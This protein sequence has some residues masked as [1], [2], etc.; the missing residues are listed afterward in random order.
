MT[1]LR[2]SY[3]EAIACVLCF[4][5]LFQ[6][7]IF[8]ARDSWSIR[9]LFVLPVFRVE[10]LG[11]FTCNSETSAFRVSL[12]QLLYSTVGR[13]EEFIVETFRVKPSSDF[14]RLDFRRTAAG[15]VEP[16]SVSAFH[17]R[18]LNY[19]DEFNKRGIGEVQ[20]LFRSNAWYKRRYLAKETET[21]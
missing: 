4:P 5:R 7:S 16:T 3:P 20:W 17:R 6:V 8:L 18:L 15:K 9:Q 21:R 1:K 2:N 19:T 12:C 14:S 11:W 13:L 10:T